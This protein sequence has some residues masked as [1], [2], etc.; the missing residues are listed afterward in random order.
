MRAIDGGRRFD[1]HGPGFTRLCED[2]FGRP[3]L[4]VVRPSLR[5]IDGGCAVATA[6]RGR[7]GHLRIVESGRR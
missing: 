1:E 6:R 7:S 4:A 2:V 3:R 5:V